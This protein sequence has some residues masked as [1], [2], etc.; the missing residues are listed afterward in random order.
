MLSLLGEK[1]KNVYPT[2]ALVFSRMTAVSHSFLKSR[3]LHRMAQRPSMSWGQ[4]FVARERPNDVD[5]IS[6]TSARCRNN[7]SI[8]SIM[9]E[10]GSM[11]KQKNG[12]DS[13]FP[14]ISYL[15][16]RISGH[17]ARATGHASTQERQAEGWRL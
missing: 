13:I 1:A 10:I 9:V 3:M 12:W 15:V 17:G 4:S 2:R 14:R 8:G 16:V 6:G 7:V 5:T 11:G